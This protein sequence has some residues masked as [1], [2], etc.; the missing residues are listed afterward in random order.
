MADLFCTIC[1]LQSVS[2]RWNDVQITVD[3]LNLLSRIFV[4]VFAF[5][6]FI[7]TRTLK[8]IQSK[9]KCLIFL[10]NYLD[11]FTFIHSFNSYFVDPL[12]QY[13]ERTLSSDFQLIWLPIEC[14]I[15]FCY[16]SIYL[17]LISI[18]SNSFKE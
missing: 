15:C 12:L 9:Q 5:I 1:F 4:F 16:I 6:I 17:I 8:H 7:G 14:V 11:S 18:H 3:R 2:S 13:F 10:I